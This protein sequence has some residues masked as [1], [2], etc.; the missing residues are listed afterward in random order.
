LWARH[1]PGHQ[2][3]HG[4]RGRE[5]AGGEAAHD[6]PVDLAAARMDDGAAGL[7]DGCVQ[8]VGADRRGRRDAEQQHQQGRHQGAAADA[9]DA[10]DGADRE[11]REDLCEIH[12]A[13]RNLLQRI[14]TIRHKPEKYFI[15]TSI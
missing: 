6:A 5:A 4:D 9:G 14:V 1:Q 12:D 15:V 3:Q 10:D 11:T 7:G 8:Q 13:L 2:R